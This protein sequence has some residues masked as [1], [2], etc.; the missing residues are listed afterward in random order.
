MVPKVY[1]LQ[2][3]LT[4][5]F[6]TVKSFN[7]Y[8]SVFVNPLYKHVSFSSNMDTLTPLTWHY[9]KT[10]YWKCLQM[11]MVLNSTRYVWSFNVLSHFH[12]KFCV[13][14]ISAKNEELAEVLENTNVLIKK[15]PVFSKVWGSLYSYTLASGFLATSVETSSGWAACTMWARIHSTDFR[16][17]LVFRPHPAHIRFSHFW[18]NRWL[19]WRL[20]IKE[21]KH[22]EPDIFTFGSWA[23]K[24]GHG[25][26]RQI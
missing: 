9:L 2:P 13:P 7:K 6:I 14:N 15:S 19:H 8:M 26:G 12:I 18:Q 25:T 10:I 5:I 11:E 16:H 1:I 24:G 4:N 23:V 21:S 3:W 20:L 22:W 17:N